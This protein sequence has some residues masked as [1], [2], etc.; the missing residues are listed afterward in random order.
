VPAYH[1]ILFGTGKALQ[2]EDQPECFADLNLDQVIS[3]ITRDKDEY[4][5]PLLFYSA[6]S[7]CSDCYFR[8]DVFRDLE[9][10]ANFATATRF[11]S[12]MSEVRANLKLTE[13]EPHVLQK[14][15]WILDAASTYVAAVL[16]MA[17]D[18][19]RAGFKS[20]GLKSFSDYLSQYAASSAFS[21]LKNDTDRTNAAIN[22]ISYELVIKNLT[23]QVRKFEGQPVLSTEIER[24]FKRFKTFASPQKRRDLPESPRVN[25]VEERILEFVAKL[26]P[27]QFDVLSRYAKRHSHFIDSGITKFDREIQFYLSYNE[28]INKLKRPGVSFC[29]P[30]LTDKAGGQ[31]VVATFDM[32]LASKLAVSVPPVVT[33]D[34]N[35]TAAER[36]A[37]VTGP[38]QGGKTTFARALGQV[39]YLASLGCPVAGT[40]ANLVLADRVLTHFEKEETVLDLR[41]KLYDDLDRIKHMLDQASS[42][43]VIILNEIFTSTTLADALFLSREIMRRVISIG[44]FTVWVTFVEEIAS[45]SKETVSMVSLVDPKQPNERT[46]KILAHPPDGLAYALAL[47]EKRR[48][49]YKQLKRRIQP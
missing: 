26:Y 33:N 12:Q 31:Q 34:I 24:T 30:R 37:V 29:Y 11:A 7:D 20:Q 8:H 44:A 15:R 35:M 41:G 46:F 16:Q 23:V 19:A 45:F 43:S 6:L 27:E 42:R 32:A 38:N 1:S 13:T 48:L 40:R 18:C 2:R 10:S 39:Y 9:S 4:E 17:E 25:H 5:L 14:E 3:A 28:Y 47:A 36:V 22:S 49:T 21:T